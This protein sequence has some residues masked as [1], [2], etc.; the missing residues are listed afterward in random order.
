MTNCLVN[1]RTG[2]SVDMSATDTSSEYSP[3]VT[4]THAGK[5]KYFLGVQPHGLQ[6]HTIRPL[7]RSVQNIN[8]SVIKFASCPPILQKKI[9]SGL[10]SL[11]SLSQKM[12]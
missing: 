2:N 3:C 10:F 9:Q 12:C 7:M 6:D 8:I 11:K 4:S 1:Q 5:L